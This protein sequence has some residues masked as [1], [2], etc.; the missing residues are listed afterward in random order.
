MR[1][2]CAPSEIYK[3]K[4]YIK[5]IIGKRSEFLDKYPILNPSPP[6]K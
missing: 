5:K 2:Y 1:E 3:I 6:S 4:Q